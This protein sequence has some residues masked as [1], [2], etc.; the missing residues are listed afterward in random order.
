[1]LSLVAP[2]GPTPIG[3]VWPHNVDTFFL[4]TL[5]LL[6]PPSLAIRVPK[7]FS[8]LIIFFS[9]PENMIDHADGPLI[10]PLHF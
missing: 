3:Q 9:T 1:M 2:S 4:P 7:L 10:L 6:C 8:S 5:T